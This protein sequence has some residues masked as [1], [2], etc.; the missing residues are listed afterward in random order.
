MGAEVGNE[1]SE[2]V[3]GAFG[4]PEVDENRDF[5]TDV[6]VQQKICWWGVCGLKSL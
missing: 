4:G 1:R 2:G 6:C 3:S 5:L